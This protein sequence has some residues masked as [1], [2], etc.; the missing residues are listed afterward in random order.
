LVLCFSAAYAA[1]V[2]KG[3]RDL[4]FLKQIGNKF[5]LPQVVKYKDYINQGFETMMLKQKQAK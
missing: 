5:V 1:D 2:I 3:A 4:K